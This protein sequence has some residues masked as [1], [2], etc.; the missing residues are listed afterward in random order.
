MGLSPD[1]WS[2]IIK[3]F[4][5]LLGIAG[6][7]AVTLMGIMI[8]RLYKSIDLLFAEIKVINR[9]LSVLKLVAMQGDPES[10]ALFRT[11]TKD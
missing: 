6:T 11:L 8:G 4:I 9:T 1:T 10:T 3:V 5:T 2:M 7:L